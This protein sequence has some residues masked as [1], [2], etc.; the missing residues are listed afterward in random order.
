MI[1][2]FNPRSPRGERLIY[3]VKKF[4]H[5]KFQSTLSSR[6][7]TTIETITVGSETISI[8]AL[9]AESDI[10]SAI[11]VVAAGNFNPRSPRGERPCLTPSFVHNFTFQSTLSS[12][13][14]TSIRGTVCRGPAISIH[15]LL[16]ESDNFL[17]F[18]CA[19]ILISIHALLAESD[20]ETVTALIKEH[21]FQSTLSSRRAT[22][23]VREF[24]N[25]FHISIHALLAESDTA[26][27][28][29]TRCTIDFNPRS[30]R[31]ERLEKSVLGCLLMGF[32][33]TLS[34]RRATSRVTAA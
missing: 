28:A 22:M 10:M 9:L 16:A 15:A 5:K 25:H 14:A 11:T 3:L 4:I 31:G 1:C 2:D 30:P 7:A 29:F 18:S 27:P 20:P 32:Q 26:T 12:R 6:R 33:S 19:A 8:H 17:V 34:S 23:K 13:R 21:R 24:I